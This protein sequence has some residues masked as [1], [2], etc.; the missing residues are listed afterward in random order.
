MKTCLEARYTFHTLLTAC[1]M[2]KDT[3]EL[4]KYLVAKAEQKCLVGIC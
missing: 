2:V 1:E 3:E 4:M